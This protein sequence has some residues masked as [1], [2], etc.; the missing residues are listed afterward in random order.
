MGGC[1]QLGWPQPQ[2]ELCP[3][4]SSEA[5]REAW[6]HSLDPARECGA[7]PKGRGFLDAEC[8]PRMAKS[9]GHVSMCTQHPA[10]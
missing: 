3:E 9:M 8:L 10:V 6:E 2:R 5:W 4:P 7:R 1:T